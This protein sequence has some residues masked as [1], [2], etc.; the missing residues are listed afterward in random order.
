MKNVSQNSRAQN[1]NYV[2]TF[3]RTA[4]MQQPRRI[5]TPNLDMTG[6]SIIA[7]IV[8]ISLGVSTPQCIAGDVTAPAECLSTA[9]SLLAYLSKKK[10]DIGSDVSKQDQWLSDNLR[11]ELRKKIKICEQEARR[12]PTD[13]IETPSNETFLRAWDRPSTYKVVGS[14]GYDGVAIVDV[15]FDWGAETNYEGNTRIQSYIFVL[16]N[17]HW[18]LDDVYGI[19]EKYAGPGNLVTDL[20]DVP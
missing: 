14:R 16:E 3:N 6:S 5:Y 1:H 2:S 12:R 20:H 15:Q 7:F 11:N 4:V 8:V 17:G 10:P 13:K 19:R 18:K 9:R